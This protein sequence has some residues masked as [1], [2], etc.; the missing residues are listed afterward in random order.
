MKKAFTLAEV[1]ITLVVIGI[2]AAITINIIFSNQ[3]E[4]YRSG[5]KKNASV[6]QQAF[7]NAALDNG[8]F[9]PLSYDENSN[10]NIEQITPAIF[11]RYMKVGKNCGE[12][13][14]NRGK[15]IEIKNLTGTATFS[16]IDS[17]TTYPS[18]VILQDG[19][20]YNVTS[21]SASPETKTIDSVNIIVDVNGIFKG[22]NRLGKDVFY[23]KYDVT[24]D[25]LRPGGS[26]NGHP[27][28][29]LCDKSS[30]NV[31]N[32]AGCAA[33]LLNNEKLPR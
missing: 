29:D 30:T 7:R 8:G 23:L 21:L 2:V 26:F 17:Y 13:S 5:L 12:V 14:C 19:T 20:F 27:Q 1:L 3:D 10:D 28:L 32:G 16:N 25:K 11:N 6:I 22:P 18:A 33:K 24:N 31:W 9:I 4:A 15:K